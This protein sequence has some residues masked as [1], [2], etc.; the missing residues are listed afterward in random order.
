[1]YEYELRNER[2]ELTRDWTLILRCA[3]SNNMVR[4]WRF[5]RHR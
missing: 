3:A 2:A 1:M 4:V 5:F